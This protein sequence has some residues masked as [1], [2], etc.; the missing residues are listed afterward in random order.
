MFNVPQLSE[1]YISKFKYVKG[2]AG[3]FHLQRK[4]DGWM[5]CCQVGFDY[6]VGLCGDIVTHTVKKSK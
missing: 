5:S 1:K 2:E 6:I 3:S 4:T